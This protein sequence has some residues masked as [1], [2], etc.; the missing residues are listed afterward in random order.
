MDNNYI[1]QI[2]LFKFQ[3]TVATTPTPPITTEL[4][5]PPEPDCESDNTY[6]V[7]STQCDKVCFSN[8]KHKMYKIGQ[9]L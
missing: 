2:L 1:I 3:T 5:L 8:V 7:A 4:P 9:E 6:Y